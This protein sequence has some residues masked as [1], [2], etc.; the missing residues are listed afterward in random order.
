MCKK[1]RIVIL[2]VEIIIFLPVSP[3]LWLALRLDDEE[4]T[5][6]KFYKGYFKMPFDEEN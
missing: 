1:I 2:L 4:M 6:K 3:L 5:F